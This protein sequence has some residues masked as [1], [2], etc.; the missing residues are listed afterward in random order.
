MG[1]H[2]L[3]GKGNA[4]FP[5]NVYEESITVPF[6]ASWKGHFPEHAVCDTCVSHYDFFPTILDL[7]GIPYRL[8]EKQPGKSF[9][10]LL[11]GNAAEESP[12]KPIV[13]YDEYGSTRMIRTEQYKYVHRFPDG[14]HELYDLKKDSGEEENLFGQK[15]TEDLVH[16]LKK[17]LLTW[18]EQYTDP[19]KDG[20][21]EP[22]NGSGQLCRCG[23][24]A[25]L[26]DAFYP[27]S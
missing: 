18:F 12:E 6:I 2:G 26:S 8:G 19:A 4:S 3:F 22:A 7:A 21:K 15:G 14:P 24:Y 11:E 17:Q 9:L 25:E 13:I 20:T 23:K 1:H 10:P 16:V 5:T 27:R